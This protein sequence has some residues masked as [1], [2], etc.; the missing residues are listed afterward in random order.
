MSTGDA[1]IRFAAPAGLD[2]EGLADRPAGPGARGHRR[3]S[4]RWPT[5]RPPRP[6]PR[7][8]PGWPTTTCRSADLRA[9]RQRLEDVFL[10]LTGDQRATRP[11]HRWATA[12]GS[13]TGPA[14]TAPWVAQSRVEVVLTARRRESVPATLGIPVLLLVFFGLVDVLPSGAENPIDT[15]APGI[16]AL[17]VMSTAFVGLAI[18][19]GFERQYRVLKRLGATPLGRGG[20]RRPRPA[21]WPSRSSR[22]PCSSRWP[23]PWA[24]SRSG[25][26]CPPRIGVVLLGTVAFAGLGLLM[27]GTL[28]GEATLA[29]ANGIY[30]VLLLLGGLL[31]PL[32]QFP[33]PLEAVA[34]LLPSAA[35][36]DA[37]YE[38]LSLGLGVPGQDWAVL[39][40]WA[41]A[42][43]LAA[44]RWFRWE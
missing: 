32:D 3:A 19:T 8:P 38:S 39:V 13:A 20:C 42:A 37:L 34:S 18:G 27:A 22:W 10:R 28:R 40:V 30:L 33:G 35:L 11:S 4:T 15:L 29:A 16:L 2:I 44:A 7:S 5:H 6:S 41:V 43:P 9:G 26:G 1:V 24:G 12:A 17:A 21:C 31:V 25:A 36:A 23:S 14:V